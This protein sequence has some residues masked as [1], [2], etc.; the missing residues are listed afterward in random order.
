MQQQQQQQGMVEV[1]NLPPGGP[2]APPQAR[3]V[4]FTPLL[5]LPPATLTT[6]QGIPAVEAI[7]EHSLHCVRVCVCVC[8]HT[9]VLCV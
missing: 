6:D 5:L 4:T 3:G 8:V 1:H 9:Y 2:L 7:T